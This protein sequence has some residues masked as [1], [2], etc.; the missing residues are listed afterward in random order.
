MNNYIIDYE[1]DNK[2]KLTK[3]YLY[4]NCKHKLNYDDKLEQTRRRIKLNQR[5]DRCLKM[6]VSHGTIET[7]YAVF[8]SVMWLTISNIKRIINKII[9]GLK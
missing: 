1:N 8:N 9:G 4:Q 3:H 6:D 7:I 5:I 2:Y